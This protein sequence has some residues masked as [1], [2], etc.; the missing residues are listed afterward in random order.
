ML[1]ED[2]DLPDEV[3]GKKYSDLSTYHRSIVSDAMP[4]VVGNEVDGGYDHNNTNF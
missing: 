1:V 2:G 3:D 4:L